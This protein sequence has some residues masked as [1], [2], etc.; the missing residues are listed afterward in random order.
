MPKIS[1]PTTKK[2]S[3]KAKKVV[4]PIKKPTKVTKKV[5]A[6]ENKEK[7][8]NKISKTYIT[9]DTEKNI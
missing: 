3:V 2:T 8:P 5:S 7:A 9:K 1:K 6:T 4:A